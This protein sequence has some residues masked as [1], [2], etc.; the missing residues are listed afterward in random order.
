MG[1]INFLLMAYTPGTSKGMPCHVMRVDFLKVT[2]RLS[3][4]GDGTL[5][6]N[7]DREPGYEGPSKK[8]SGLLGVSPGRTVPHP[9]PQR[10]H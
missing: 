3:A 10:S 6:G 8:S 4:A 7:S 2:R 1:Y 5:F 9:V